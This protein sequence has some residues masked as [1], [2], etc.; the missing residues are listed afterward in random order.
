M[1]MELRRFRWLLL[2]AVCTTLWEVSVGFKFP[3]LDKDPK[4]SSMNLGVVSD[5][6]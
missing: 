5:V 1:S 2:L 3:H 6:C 4:G